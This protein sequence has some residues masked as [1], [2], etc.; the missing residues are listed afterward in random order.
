[1]IK[2]TFGLYL[3][4]YFISSW[5]RIDEEREVIILGVHQFMR[6][7]RP[8]VSLYKFSYLRLFSKDNLEL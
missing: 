3:L 8:L 4:Y 2:V 7:K 5:F 1:M 6:S